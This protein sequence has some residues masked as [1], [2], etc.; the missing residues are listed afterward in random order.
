[1]ALTSDGPK[2]KRS[3][4]CHFG[5]EG[6]RLHNVCLQ[7]SGLDSAVPSCHAFLP[8]PCKP[9]NTAPRPR[10]Q[11]WPE[12]RLCQDG[13]GT[14]TN[15][16]RQLFGGGVSF[17]CPARGL[18]EPSE[19]IKLLHALWGGGPGASKP[20]ARRT[21]S[22]KGPKLVPAQRPPCGAQFQLESWEVVTVLCGTTLD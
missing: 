14:R 1:L 12:W 21:H 13:G 15:M 4:Q 22:P 10:Q 16:P 7:E 20:A 19:Y 18:K 2:K 8:C 11:P 3:T 5:H 17:A 6:Q 9:P